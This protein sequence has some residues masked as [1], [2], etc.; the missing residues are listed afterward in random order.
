[1]K[2][3]FL[4]RFAAI[5]LCKAVSIFCGLGIAVHIAVLAS[6]G[7][8]SMGQARQL[9][10]VSVEPTPANAVQ[11]GS[12]TFSATGTFN[13]APTTQTNLAVQWASSDSNVV[14]VDPNTGVAT[15]LLVGGPISITASAAGNG[16]MVAGSGTSSTQWSR[17]M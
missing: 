16:G 5:A 15:C 17:T 14:T 11:L 7:G 1:M 2:S 10:A 12:I 6:C 4:M 3:R 9:V 13:Q 8:G